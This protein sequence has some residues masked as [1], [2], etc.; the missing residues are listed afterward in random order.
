[1]RYG[2]LCGGLSQ[3]ESVPLAWNTDEERCSCEPVPAPDWFQ[4]SCV[5]IERAPDD[6]TDRPKTSK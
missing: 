5:I 3:E 4:N 1:M 6:I 2:A